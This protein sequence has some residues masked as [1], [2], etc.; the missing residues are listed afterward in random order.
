MEEKKGG[1]REIPPGG[2]GAFI[3]FQRLKDRKELGW[4]TSFGKQGRNGQ[5]HMAMLFST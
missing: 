2:E 4:G 5:R 1:R 3:I